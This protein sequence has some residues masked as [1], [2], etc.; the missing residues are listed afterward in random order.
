MTQ[1]DVRRALRTGDLIRLRRGWY[2]A[3]TA[4]A[5][6]VEAVAGGGV[7]SC[8]SALRWHGVWVPEQPRGTHTR[9]NTGR[10]RLGRHCSQHGRPVAEHGAVDDIPIALRHAARCLDDEGFIVVCDSILASGQLRPE[11]LE[12]VLQ[13]APART[14]AL[15]EKCDPHAESGTETMV[16]LRLRSRNIRVRT[17]VHITRVGR[18][19]LVVGDRLIIETDGE[20]YHS[21]IEK[22]T[23]D[24]RRD[25]EAI[26]QGYLPLRFT[27]SDVVD[28]W[29]ITKRSVEDLVATR[30]HQWPRHR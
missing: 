21:G 8:V 20:R 7:L 23:E 9:A 17:Q 28:S 16:R 30:R 29:E 22:F 6:V 19:D 13:G 4:D 5:R 15:L 11:D 12:A 14:I 18:V 3:S 10:D 26:R 24:R 25:R 2:A 1:A 27:Y